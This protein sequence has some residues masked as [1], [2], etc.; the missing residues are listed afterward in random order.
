M[1]IRFDTKSEVPIYIQL[2]N[3]IIKGIAYGKLALGEQLPT[4]RQLAVDAGIN[5]MT[6]N[7][8]YQ[9]LKAEGIIEI[10]RR[11]GATVANPI[12][13]SALFQ[14]KLKEEL[15]L[16]TAE[17]KIKGIKKDEFLK[18]GNAMYDAM[19]NVREEE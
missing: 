1:I 12:K 10:D 13:Q 17:A 2:R 9:I 19:E 6:V 16:L 5:A 18:I 8:A 15:A 3:Q 11:L 4:V 7:K 14:E